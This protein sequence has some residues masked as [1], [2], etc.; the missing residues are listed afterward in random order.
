MLLS[1][2]NFHFLLD[3]E[4]ITVNQGILSKSQTHIP[5]G[6]IQ[7]I[8]TSQ[9]LF[10]RFFN[11]IDLKI[12]NATQGGGVQN[13]IYYSNRRIGERIGVF[14]NTIEIPGLDLND[15]QKLKDAIL[16]KVKSASTDIHSGL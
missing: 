10:D 5:Y 2:A 7:N 12:Q 8:L 16:N 6:V 4:Y 9:D 13:A 3:E 14:G 1:R 11:V 15:A